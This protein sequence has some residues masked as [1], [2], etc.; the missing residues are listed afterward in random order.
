MNKVTKEILN[1]EEYK[2][3]H[4]NENLGENII[5]LTLSGSIG[6][7][8]N[9]DNS[10]VDLRGITIERK[11]NIYGFQSF[12][13]FE[14]TATDTVIYGLRKFVSLAL[15]GNPNILELLGTKDEHII[16]MNKYGE[17]LRKNRE[18][19]LSKRVI[20]T[21]G[22]YATAQLRRLQNALARDEY[23]KEEKEK[24]ILNTINNQ[25]N[26]FSSNYTEFPKG[27][28]KLYIDKSDKN[29][30][31]TEILMDI[32]ID[33]YSLRDFKS[34][35]SEMS[36]IVHDYDKLN[37]RNRKKDDGKLLKHAMHLIRLLIMGTE[38]LKTHEINTYRENEHD[39]LMDIRKGKYSYDELFKLVELYDFNF[40]EASVNTT[41]PKEPDERQVEE[42]LISLYERYYNGTRKIIK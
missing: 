13:Q 22:N 2:F 39:L 14:D 9:I 15:K 31:E 23:P 26:H 19:F 8:T 42:L 24:H 3:I 16:Y 12:E 4:S 7:G 21:F 40:K 11:E 36:N 17:A 18:L 28:I 6:Y 1:K 25:M 38:I 37:H 32:H 30:I 27:S 20:H 29:E 41:L 5:Y 10:D 34:I 35:Y 33:K